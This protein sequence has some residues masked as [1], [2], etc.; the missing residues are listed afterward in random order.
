MRKCLLLAKDILINKEKKDNTIEL[1]SECSMGVGESLGSFYRSLE[2]RYY[3]GLDWLDE[4]GLSL[5]P[6]VEKL[7]DNNIPSFPIA[8]L[9]VVLVLA[10]LFFGLGMII[11]PQ[12]KITLIVSD[13]RTGIA[14]ADAT[15]LVTSASG[16]E[17]AATTDEEG[18]AEILV[19]AEEIGVEVSKAGYETSS[20]SLT[21]S[22]I[23]EREVELSRGVEMFNRTIQLMQKGTSQLFD[24]DIQVQFRCSNEDSDFEATKTSSSGMIDLDV[25]SDCGNIIASPV[26]GFSTED[27]VISLEE[28]APQLFLEAVIV[29]TGTV[30]V[31]VENL[32]GEVLGGMTVMVYSHDSISL[33][34][35]YTNAAGT[36]VFDSIPTGNVFVTV[37][38]EQGRHA[39]FDSSQLGAEG[40]KE[41]VKD[42]MVSF[43]VKLQEAVAGKVKVM[44]KDSLTQE[45]VGNA[46][47][48]LKKD[49]KKV[50]EEYTNSEGRAEF[51]VSENVEFDLEVDAEGYLIA[52]EKNVKTSESFNTVYLEPASADNSQLLS[53]EVVDSRGKPIDNVRLVLKKADGTIFANNVVTG[54]DG[55][56]EFANL[57]LESYYVYAVK[58]GF[59][60]ENSDP[61]TVKARQENKLRVVLPIGFGNLEVL[62]LNDELQPVQGAVVEAINVLN[63]QKEFEE[64]TNLEG[65]ANFDFRADKKVYF[66]VDAAEFLPYY[67]MAVMP[68]AGSTLT[69]EIVLAKD[70]GQLQVK[71]MGLYHEGELAPKELAPGAKYTAKLLLLLPKSSHF[72][73]AG[74]HLRVG[75]ADEGKTNIMEEDGIYLR[76]VVGSTA[77][78]LKGTSFTPPTGYAI[79]SGNL[80]TGDS[81]WA[82]LVWENVSQGA[83]AV[84]AEVQ[85]EESAQLGQILY[86]SYRGWGKESRTTRFPADADLAGSESTAAKH[87]LYAN[88]RQR[89]YTAG[90]SNLC[91]TSF[92]KTFSIEDNARALKVGVT[93]Q[94]SAT[95]GS[96]YKLNFL[97]SS[98]ADQAFTNAEIELGSKGDGLRFEN[99]AITDAT[100]LR[101][102]GTV[103]GY[104]FSKEIGDMRK[105]SSVFG[106][107]DFKTEKE[108]SNILTI[109]IKSNN[110]P[111]LTETIDIKV[112]AAEQLRLD[113]IPKEVI[114]GIDNKVLI[115]VTGEAEEPVSNAVVSVNLDDALVLSR[116]SNGS[117]VV[118]FELESPG[119]GSKLDIE[120]S[121]TGYREAILEMAIDSE[122]L[123]VTPPEINEK[124]DIARREV[125]KQIWLDNQTITDLVISKLSFSRSFEGLVEFEWEDDYEGEQLKADTDMNIFLSIGLTD[126][127]MLVTK[128]VKLEGSL[129]V[130]SFS[131]EEQLTFV[132]NVPI[133]IRISLGGDVDQANCLEIVP[134]NWE[135]ITSSDDQ[136]TMDFTLKNNCQVQDSEI[137]LSSLEAK[138][139]AGKS[140]SLGKFTVSS[141]E[142]P[143]AKTAMLSENAVEIAETVPAGFEGKITI[144]FGPNTGI[145]SGTA[146]PKLVFVAKHASSK[147]EEKIS[148]KLPVELHVSNLSKCVE[149]V[150][151]EPIIVET[152]P[153]NMGYGN[154]RGSY[155][156]YGGVGYGG[157]GAGGYSGYGS[158]GGYGAGGYTGYGGYGG[159]SSYPGNY[160]YGNL[161]GGSGWM[162][163]QMYPNPN[164]SSGYY[165]NYY[166]RRQ[167]NSWRYGLG[168]STFIVKNN[169]ASEVEIDLDLGSRLRVENDK[170][171]LKPNEDNSVRVESGYRM[172]KYDI[173]VFAKRKGSEDK[174]QKIDSVDVIVRR[175]GEIDEECIKLSSTKIK[176]NDFIGQPVNSEIYNY[177]Y[178]VGVRL[179]R[180]PDVI[181]FY[182]KLAGQ[183][184]NEYRL[185]REE[186]FSRISLQTAPYTP[187]PNY[188][189]PGPFNQQGMSSQGYIPSGM[190]GGAI[191]GLGTYGN[192]CDMID[193]VIPTDTFTSGDN[194]GRTIETV[195]YRIRPQLNYRKMVCEHMAQ[196]PFQSIFG[197]RVM[198]SQ[199]YYRVFVDAAALVSYSNPFGGTTNK[200]FLVELEDIWGIGDTIDECIHQSGRPPV[201]L[202]K[203]IKCREKGKMAE[204]KD[205]VDQAVFDLTK[206]FSATKGFIPQSAFSE[207]GIFIYETEPQAIMIPPA[208]AQDG[209]T[210]M[211]PKEINSPNGVNVR[212]EPVAGE[213][214]SPI[215]A[216]NWSVKMTVD[217]TG[218]LPNVA[219]EVIDEPVTLTIER[220]SMWTG[221]KTVPVNVKM[222]V[223]NKGLDPG[224]IDP[225]TCGTPGTVPDTG[226]D[227]DPDTGGG[228]VLTATQCDGGGVTNDAYQNYG[229]HR[230]PF[231]WDWEGPKEKIIAKNECDEKGKEMFCDAL[232]FSIELNKKGKELKEVVDLV[233][234]NQEIT[235]MLT[236]VVNLGS[237]NLYEYSNSRNLFRWVKKQVAIRDDAEGKD[238]VFF[239]ETEDKLLTRKLEKGNSIEAAV[240]ILAGDPKDSTPDGLAA[241][242]G[243]MSTVLASL[244]NSSEEDAE[245]VVA[246]FDKQSFSASQIEQ[247]G[248]MGIEYQ[249]K[250][251]KY[252]WT[253]NEFKKFH[254]NVNEALDT[255]ESSASECFAD[256]SFSVIATKKEEAK[257]CSVKFVDGSGSTF[258]LENGDLKTILNA[259]LEFVVGI[260]N[261]ESVNVNEPLGKKVIKEAADLT[262]VKE[263]LDELRYSSFADFYDKIVEFSAFLVKDGYSQGLLK[264]VAEAYPGAK[265]M[266]FDEGWAVILEIEGTTA[267]TSAG[268]STKVSPI[269]LKE[270]G[271]YAV[272]LD[273]K[274]GGVGEWEVRLVKTEALPRYYAENMFFQ[275][276]FD[277]ELGKNADRQGYGISY[278]NTKGKEITLTYDGSRLPQDQFVRL[279]P[280]TNGGIKNY[281]LKYGEDFLSTKGG[282][283]M[284]I[285]GNG[286]E[287]NPST[288]KRLVLT[289]GQRL[290]TGPEGI[291]Y[292]LLEGGSSLLYK[293]NSAYK[294]QSW[295]A[296]E[297]IGN[298]TSYKKAQAQALCAEVDADNYHGFNDDFPSQSKKYT[299]VTIV[300]VDKIYSVRSICNQ[301]GATLKALGPEINVGAGHRKDGRTIALNDG[302]S[303]TWTIKAYIDKIK[304][305]QVC[306]DSSQGGMSL[307]WN[308]KEFYEN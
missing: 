119:S 45:P 269:V 11:M 161:P 75:D 171:E 304:I 129:S 140:N 53:V 9:I 193:Q 172:G 294:T 40:V 253:F 208:G 188:V 88:T 154:Y 155:N 153:F 243:F 106:F 218:M 160:G 201:S 293:P 22:G 232:Q 229:F 131:Q 225:K 82:N 213:C 20:F 235:Q 60:G 250:L 121:K 142:L 214:W 260:R 292:D 177:C 37:N 198:L 245:S 128:P 174:K 233:N 124:L 212:L 231:T 295:F 211:Q 14:L 120:A 21:V 164:Y 254:E 200:Y 179:R 156:P 118:E 297:G 32:A 196:T 135:V 138:V 50:S 149:V 90:P 55:M 228:T 67:S 64:I 69:I 204:A 302:D 44:L 272:L 205:I 197:L 270:A 300:P 185:E 122:I 274:F 94:Y 107:I 268:Q 180:G 280:R 51:S 263:K 42:G 91:G 301:G 23:E 306:I 139:E 70:P 127:G 72:N 248:H 222:M 152:M 52:I 101:S 191:L 81:K 226:P 194:E 273:Y 49:G 195:Q 176:L 173:G 184:M 132:E 178:D 282:T 291:V 224:S 255:I 240:D 41:L 15:V 74:L 283:I 216:G 261:I 48:Y 59:E 236:T 58:K 266:K 134:V 36:I 143:D 278:K 157:Y 136:E 19:P 286:I 183:P 10:G 256:T 209:I 83:Y 113:I 241:R 258:I 244:Q 115:R 116:E 65:K 103:E 146:K 24:E 257:V 2:D 73:E 117:G 62:I 287:F 76:G 92:C 126:K 237:S 7:E 219:C 66:K 16:Q 102:E 18:N 271:K 162:G 281:T 57:P 264:D 96:S 5:F 125:E 104:A 277:G 298:D 6:I 34:T 25:P 207:R 290:G 307:T 110:Q 97:I 242:L 68:D 112:A 305:G 187:G 279:F 71:L 29:N 137:V 86:I 303:R 141:D 199:A 85:V 12:A 158:Y 181:R 26:S 54:S 63:D 95:I 99:Y 87:A 169:C 251:D 38:D 31:L 35:G 186:Q 221:T 203:M 168:E 249:G 4:K 33:G 100:G 144:K 223:L 190:G 202:E 47:V 1:A 299:G 285:S 288:A 238:L 265:A 43:E 89:A 13:A 98:T 150:A 296:W 147:G 111:V 108:G 30:N 8:I 93:S 166:D 246:M 206:N 167:D 217:R 276:P 105:E 78:I 28:Q 79:D 84:E 182:C 130:H 148:V 252:V 46:L 56:G 61:I 227:T 123:V 17:I 133:E 247:F 215:V 145:D 159:Y 289:L 192:Q 267:W 230:L 151:E 234:N 210:G 175:Q 220:P 259:N 189:Q 308:K 39:F 3:S 284:R 77:S 275:L 27:G 239:L 80:T 262:E 170:F 114:P 165:S 163:G 109:T